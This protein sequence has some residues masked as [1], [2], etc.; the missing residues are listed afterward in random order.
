MLNRKL[1]VYLHQHLVYTETLSLI[2]KM[3]NTIILILILTLLSCKK[4]D[5]TIVS[6]Q[7]ND[8]GITLN[9]PLSGSLQNPT[10]SPDDNSIIFTRFINGYNIEPAEIYKF[11]LTTEN[12]TLLVSDGS[13]NVNLPGSSWKNGKIIFSSSREPHD[14]IYQINENGQAGDEI[15]ITNRTNKV[16]Y[17]P[18]FNPIGDWTV[19]ESHILDVEGDGI[20]TKYKIDGTSNYVELTDQGDDCRQPNWSPA[21]NK[22]LYQQKI[23]GQWNIWIIDI[24]G[25]NK[26]QVTSNLGNCTDASFTSDGQSIIFSS[27]F[28]VNIANIYKISID[29]TNPIR[30]TTFDGYDGAVSISNNGTKLIFESINEDPDE[31]N[32]TKIVL[33]EL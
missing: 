18:T 4:D 15:Q 13:A 5:E 16:A 20:I 17:E 6:E 11:E 27:D 7:R 12:L 10:F 29:G 31:S 32:G 33:L 2:K 3:K 22:I 8:N 23:N 19:F 9:I 30:L 1:V 26:T 24:D 14:E 28:Q 21:N 25:T